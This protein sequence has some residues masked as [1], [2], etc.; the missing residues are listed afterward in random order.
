MEKQIAIKLKKK[1]EEVA[2]IYSNPDR[3]YN[4]YGE[5]FKIDRIIALS[6]RTAAVSYLKNSGKRAAVFF[7]YV[8]NYWEYFFPTDSHIIGMLAFPEIKKKIEED[9]F[10]KNFKGDDQWPEDV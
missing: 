5:I 9:N 8:K 1:A 7:H 6:G 2:R 3:E 10:D 4:P